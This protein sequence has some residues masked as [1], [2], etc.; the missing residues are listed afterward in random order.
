MWPARSLTCKVTFVPG[1]LTETSPTHCPEVNFNVLNASTAKAPP[2][3]LAVSC[4]V[5]AKAR[6]V[7]PVEDFAVMIIRNGT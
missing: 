7:A 4:T 6:T 2:A 1:P 5:P 3:P